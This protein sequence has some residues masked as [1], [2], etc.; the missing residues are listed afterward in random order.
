[1]SPVAMTP[2]W[3][4]WCNNK[5]G[6]ARAAKYANTGRCEPRRLLSGSCNQIDLAIAQLLLSTSTRCAKCALVVVEDR[7]RENEECFRL[8]MSEV[9]H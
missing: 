4:K 7:R 9:R 1:M 8:R 5:A 2:A 3:M 6:L